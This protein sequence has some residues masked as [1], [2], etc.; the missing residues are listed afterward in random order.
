MQEDFRSLFDRARA[1]DAAARGQLFERHLSG[2]R[3]YV[4]LK[5][6]RLVR[7]R[8]SCSDL[9]QSVCREALADLS[10]VECDDEQAF[11]RWLYRVGL[12]KI[13]RRV[14]HHTAQKR[15]AAR[16]VASAEPDEG[17]GDAAVLGAYATFCTPS[18]AAAAREEV[19]RVERAFDRLPAEYREI[20]LQARLEERPHGEIAAELGKSV[21]A[22]RKLLSRARAR[23][24]LLLD[25]E[26]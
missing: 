4:R 18:R 3:A 6:G 14:D 21:V 19:E 2:L 10:R 1:G 8:E 17:P 20:I 12:H 9:V 16:E 23:L 13:L 7:A 11:R 26:A 5:S 22:V 25:A 24:A 15:D